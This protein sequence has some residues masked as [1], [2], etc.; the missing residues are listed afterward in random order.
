MASAV[1]QLYLS[2]VCQSYLTPTPSI[3]AL[4]ASIITI[5][6]QQGLV[7]PTQLIPTLIAMSTD[8]LPLEDA[9]A[10]TA[11][12]ASRPA[13]SPLGSVATIKNKAETLLAELE[14]RYPGFVHVCSIHVIDSCVFC[15]IH[16]LRQQGIA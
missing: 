5:V 11:P 12:D 15:K 6:L 2:E 8:A 13:L 14:K 1:M 9:L 10:T 7:H 3:R 16:K 4:S